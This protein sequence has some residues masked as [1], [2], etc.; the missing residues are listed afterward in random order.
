MPIILLEEPETLYLSQKVDLQVADHEESTAD[1]FSKKM[2][3]GTV[4]AVIERPPIGK[5]ANISPIAA[6]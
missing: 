4:P 5:E 2:A 3:I 6:P 1:R